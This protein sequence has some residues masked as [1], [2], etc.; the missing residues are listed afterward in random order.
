MNL[1]PSLNSS[2][3]DLEPSII[4]RAVKAGGASKSQL[5]SQLTEAGVGLNEF[6]RVLFA[7]DLFITSP[8]EQHWMTV[9]VSV[10]D[11]GFSQGACIQDLHSRASALGLLPPPLELAPHLRLQYLDQPEG[12]WGHPVTQHRAPPGSI[13]I[14]SLP[15]SEDDDFPKGFYLRRIEGTLWLRGYR[16]PTDNH[17]HPDDHILFCQA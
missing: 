2:L 13:T 4:R 14:A 5:L 1:T 16:C 8:T 15:L 9:E 3:A 7:S 17:W 6:A 12:F 11:L 10:H